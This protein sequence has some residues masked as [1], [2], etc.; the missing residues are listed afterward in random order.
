MYCSYLP[1]THD[2]TG[3]PNELYLSKRNAK[4]TQEKPKE[5]NFICH[6]MFKTLSY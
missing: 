6:A 4:S 5:F 2:F 3:F 1:H